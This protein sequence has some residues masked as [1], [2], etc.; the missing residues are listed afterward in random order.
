MF[1][2]LA[3]LR[4]PAQHVGI[5][6][7]SPHASALLEIADTSKGVLLPRMTHA[8]RDAITAPA[9]GLMIFDVE[10]SSLYYYNGQWRRMPNDAEVWKLNGSFALGSLHFLGTLID[11]DLNFRIESK[12]AGL[13]SASAGNTSL[14]Y[15]AINNAAPGIFNTAIGAAALK[16]NTGNGNTATGFNTLGSNTTGTFNTAAGFGALKQVS[17]GSGN[18]AVGR[19]ANSSITTGSNNVSVGTFAGTGFNLNNSVSI[20]FFAQATADNMIRLGNSSVTS[21]QGQVP[22][23][24][25]SD[26]RF[27]FNVQENVKGLDFILQLRPVTY[28]FDTRAYDQF[29]HQKDTISRS[30]QEKLDYRPSSAIVHT[31]FI[32]QEVEAAARNTGFHFDGLMVPGKE[33]ESYGIAY[34]QFVVP[35]V[36][37]V[38]E[39]QSAIRTLQQQ[40]EELKNEI[41]LLKQTQK[42]NP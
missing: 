38:Q 13:I 30:V 15:E 8:Q 7:S 24:V 36:K 2:I 4:L 33:T 9:L 41:R 25:P 11:Q 17:T 40:N 5:G 12:R 39:Q 28:Q 42:N 34:A 14:G 20:G 35:L 6:T 19:D 1:F 22:F 26:G 32:A 37:A 31:G 3:L 27:K 23:T 21:I 29:L 16:L 18:V 10:D